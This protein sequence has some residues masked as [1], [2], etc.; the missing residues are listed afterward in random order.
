MV[1]IEAGI[2]NLPK[3]DIRLGDITVSIPQDNHPG[4][5]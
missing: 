4:V 1:G 3:H 2:P 5:V